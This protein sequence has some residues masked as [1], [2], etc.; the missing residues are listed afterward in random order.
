MSSGPADGP[1]PDD[2]AARER[3][4]L[5]PGV[6]FL[7]HGSFGATP[8]AVLDVQ[9]VPGDPEAEVIGSEFIAPSVT[10]KELLLEEFVEAARR[11]P[12]IHLYDTDARGY[13]LLA[14]AEERL[15]ATYRYVVSITEPESDAR[16]GTRWSVAAGIPGARLWEA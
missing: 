2:G 5:D 10:S 12:H 4:T 9:A 8:R 3:W 14:F 16:D 6:R 15:D 11:N 1:A 13:L 7:N